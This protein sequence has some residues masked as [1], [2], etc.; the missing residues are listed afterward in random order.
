MVVDFVVDFVVEVVVGVVATE[1]A[2]DVEESLHCAA[3]EEL[4]GPPRS[5]GPLQ[6]QLLLEW[7]PAAFA[8]NRNWRYCCCTHPRIL[9]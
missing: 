4:D 9:F 3:L 5:D 2:R 7:P 6:N 8:A 1:L